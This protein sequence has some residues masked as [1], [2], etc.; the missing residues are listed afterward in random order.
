MDGNKLELAKDDFVIDFAEREGYAMASRDSLIVFISTARN[1]EMMARGLIRD[2]ARRLQVLRKERGYN[3]TDVLEL[4]YVLGLDGESLEMA[5]EKQ[6]ELAFLVRVKRIEF[7]DKAESYKDE[8][9]D[10]QK[11]QISVE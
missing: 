1:R 10:G 7:S 11:I 9:I 8:D 4:A 5:K 6:S 2:I 3:P